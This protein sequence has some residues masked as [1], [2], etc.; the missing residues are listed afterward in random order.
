M[1]EAALPTPHVLWSLC[2]PRVGVGGA[3]AQGLQRCFSSGATWGGV[4]MGAPCSHSSLTARGHTTEGQLSRLPLPT[5]FQNL[6]EGSKLYVSLPFASQK[7][8]RIAG[9]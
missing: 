8:A 6:P 5:S 9:I 7:V 2:G 3:L 4:I 1:A